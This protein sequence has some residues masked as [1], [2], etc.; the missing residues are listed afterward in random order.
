MAVFW[1]S[2]LTAVHK[3]ALVNGFLSQTVADLVR[4]TPSTTVLIC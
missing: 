3:S 1:F 2:W 4:Q